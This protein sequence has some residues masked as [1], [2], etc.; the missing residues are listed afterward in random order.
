MKRR[1]SNI[2]I[3]VLA[4]TFAGVLTGLPFTGD[5]QAQA[6]NSCEVLRVGHVSDRTLEIHREL[7]RLFTVVEKEYGELLQLSTRLLELTARCDA[8]HCKTPTKSRCPDQCSPNSCDLSKSK[9]CRPPSS[10]DK[11]TCP[12]KVRKEIDKL[13]SR[14][15]NKNE[16]IKD[17][18]IEIGKLGFPVSVTLFGQT[19]GGELATLES[20]LNTSKQKMANYNPSS[21]M[22]ISCNEAKSLGIVR[23]CDD[24]L[25]TIL[26]ITIPWTA[27]G[28]KS[29]FDYLIC[30]R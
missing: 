27:S 16:R 26:G 18:A 19:V 4:L 15:E 8:N 22:L 12:D 2:V 1:T 3:L 10:G 21:E 5:Q 24:K 20:E 23:T 30:P 9:P 28:P 17:A 6:Q 25:R 13:Y 7:I 29:T 14:I 11:D